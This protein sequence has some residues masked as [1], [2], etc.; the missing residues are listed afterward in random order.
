MQTEDDLRK[1]REVHIKSFKAKAVRELLAQSVSP[2]A[3][4]K[5]A[6]VNMCSYI[7]GNLVAVAL[8][9]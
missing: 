2:S 7:L 8:V 1:V 9:T 6:S 5:T 3:S 4:S